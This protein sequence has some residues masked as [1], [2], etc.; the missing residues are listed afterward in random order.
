MSLE[1]PP[2]STQVAGGSSGHETPDIRRIGLFGGTFDPPHI[3]HLILAETVRDE[4]GLDE[5]RFVVANDPWQKTSNRFISEAGLRLEMVRAALDGV[6]GMTASGVEIELGGPSYSVV[7]LEHLRHDEPDVSWLL[8]VGADAAAGLDT[9][10][11]SDELAAQ[12]DVVVVN[13]P[14][15][16][17]ELDGGGRDEPAVPPGWRWQSVDIP[18]IGVSSTDLRARVADGRSIRFLTPA[19]VALIIERSQLYRHDR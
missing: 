4:L 8:I 19:R 13:R 14:S 15:L 3:G 16:G 6:D 9:W 18:M 11:R 7:T 17:V 2:R 1:D 5:I 10:H 12:V